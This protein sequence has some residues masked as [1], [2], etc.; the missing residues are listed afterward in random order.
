MRSLILA[1][2]ISAS[3]VASWGQSVPTVQTTNSTGQV[4]NRQPKGTSV[5]GQFAR[6]VVATPPVV[7][8]TNS[9]TAPTFSRGYTRVNLRRPSAP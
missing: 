6:R 1:L 8:T 3:T 9:Y 4:V 2:A 7:S 5:G